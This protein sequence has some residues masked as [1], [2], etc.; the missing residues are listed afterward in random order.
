MRGRYV[1]AQAWYALG[2]SVSDVTNPAQPREIAYFQAG[3]RTPE[4]DVNS[5][6]DTWSSYF[7]RGF[8]FANDINRGFETLFLRD[9]ARRQARQ[10][11]YDNPQTQ[12]RVLFP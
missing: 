12:Q 10:L 11:A 3:D 7:Y 1:Y 8:V 4:D 2:T 9:P 5:S 6:A